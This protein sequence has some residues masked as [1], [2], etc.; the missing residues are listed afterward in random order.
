MEGGDLFVQLGGF[1]DCILISILCTCQVF[2]TK[3]NSLD[4]LIEGVLSAAAAAVVVVVAAAVVVV[5]IVPLLLLLLLLLLSLLFSSSLCRCCCCCCRCCFHRPFV[6]V[7][8]DFAASDNRV[9]RLS[10]I[11]S[12]PV[13]EPS[14]YSTLV[15][16]VVNM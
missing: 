7:V 2:S 6:V 11:G 9:V 15:C 14:F 3:N 8:V 13:P 10:V 5:F 12:G 1:L 4:L 16:G